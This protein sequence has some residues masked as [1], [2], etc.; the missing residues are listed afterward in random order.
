MCDS[1]ICGELVFLVLIYRAYKSLSIGLK[2]TEK[3]DKI[4]IIGAISALSGFLLQ[5]M[6]DYTF[7]NYRVML[8]FWAVLGIS[9]LYADIGNLRED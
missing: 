6:F 7:Y 2:N 1:G 9:T 8:I 5:S 3:K 4:F